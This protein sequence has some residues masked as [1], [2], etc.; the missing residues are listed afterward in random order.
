MDRC[1]TLA[2]IGTVVTGI[3]LAGTV[4]PG[5]EIDL[6]SGRFCSAVGDSGRL[7]GTLERLRTSD[8]SAVA[9]LE[10]AYGEAY[11][12]K[13]SAIDELLSPA[14]PPGEREEA[15]ARVRQGEARFL[16]P[17][18]LAIAAC[19]GDRMIEEEVEAVSEVL[20]D[21]AVLAGFYS[22]GEISPHATGHC[23]LHN[24]T[25]T[26]TVLGERA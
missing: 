22:Y 8:P 13:R 16:G 7:I 15:R 17:H 14:A 19:D 2:G 25:M 26:I 21:G 5:D 10:T 18:R 11:A 23:D 20:G 9:R 3:P 12:A 6:Y 1:F 4:A 24:Q